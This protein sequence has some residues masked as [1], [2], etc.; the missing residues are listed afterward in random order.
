MEIIKKIRNWDPVE[1]SL[2][3]PEHPVGVS[4]GVQGVK[5]LEKNHGFLMVFE[6]IPGV[7]KSPKN[8]R[9]LME[10]TEKSA[11][12]SANQRRRRSRQSQFL[13]I[14]SLKGLVLLSLFNYLFI[15]PIYLSIY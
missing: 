12:P 10:V 2:G 3:V 5:N 7:W 15:Y 1:V 13:C 14:V 9:K 11:Q 6:V 8:Q 4:L